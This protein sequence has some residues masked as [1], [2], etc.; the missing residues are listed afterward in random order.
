VSGDVRLGYR[1][2]MT[3]LRQLPAVAALVALTACTSS[4]SSGG[5]EASTTSSA[6]SAS[7]SSVAS[8]SV[9]PSATDSGSQ[10]ASATATS[11]A[12]ATGTG[13]ELGAGKDC[14]TLSPTAVTQIVGFTVKAPLVAGSG[15][16]VLCTFTPDSVADSSAVGAV[17]IQKTTGITA[18]SFAATRKAFEA[19]GQKTVDL[20]GLGD[21][22]YSSAF[23][24]GTFVTAIV[25]VRKGTTQ[26]IVT[27]SGG[28]V[29][30][31]KAKALAQ[32]ALT[33]FGL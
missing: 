3:R 27:M 28:N 30:L 11:A 5:T 25:G 22:A 2:I 32:L 31:D 16:V 9:T 21:D 7:G 20:P 1:S 26:V 18:A 17:V 15:P 19:G 10:S 8:S 23:G 33:S 29:T 6:A 14:S 12:T 4:T 24:A 13:T